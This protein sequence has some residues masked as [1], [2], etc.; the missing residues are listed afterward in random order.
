MDSGVLGLLYAYII[1]KKSRLI[2]VWA[3]EVKVK[4]RKKRVVKETK[5]MWNLELGVSLPSF[6][7]SEADKCFTRV[8]TAVD[9]NTVVKIPLVIWKK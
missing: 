6:P 1:L 2:S 8:V 7:E 3:N 4:T 9:E 5:S